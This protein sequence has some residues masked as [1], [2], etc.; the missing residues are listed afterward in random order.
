MV[1]GNAC[2]VLDGGT[3]D[4]HPHAGQEP[5]HHR[6]A[7]PPMGG[8]GGGGVE[9]MGGGSD[10][11][12][13]F[14]GRGG[15]GAGNA[16]SGFGPPGGGPAGLHHTHSILLGGKVQ[17]ECLKKED[18][19]LI[20]CVDG[21]RISRGGGL[22]STKPAKTPS[23]KRLGTKM[24]VCVGK[25]S[26]GAAGAGRGGE[27]DEAGEVVGTE[28]VGGGGDEGG[29]G[30]DGHQQRREELRRQLAG[31]GPPP[32]PHPPGDGTG[33]SERM[34]VERIWKGVKSWCGRDLRCTPRGSKALKQFRSSAIK[35]SRNHIHCENGSTPLRCFGE[36]GSGRRG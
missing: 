2:G 18:D 12:G 16:K 7:Q 6:P 22:H 9:M 20:G 26:G 27:L 31:G 19:I 25:R 5:P 29:G 8:G 10:V 24:K 33:P 11:C 34:K 28:D 15:G 32:A 13:T 23:V 4:L 30:G 3:D 14:G 17:K 36:G 35:T 21:N 1:K